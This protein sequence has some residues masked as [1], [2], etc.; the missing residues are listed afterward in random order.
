MGKGKK[1]QRKTIP[2][3]GQTLALRVAENAERKRVGLKGTKNV[4]PKPISKDGSK[5]SRRG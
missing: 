5:I 1:E 2:L 4:E 3:S